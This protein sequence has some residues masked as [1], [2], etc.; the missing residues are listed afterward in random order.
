MPMFLQLP[1]LHG[2][3][4]SVEAHVLWRDVCVSVGLYARRGGRP[5]NLYGVETYVSLCVCVCVE[6]LLLE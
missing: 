6:R 4:K 3:T 5:G 1:Y 2:E